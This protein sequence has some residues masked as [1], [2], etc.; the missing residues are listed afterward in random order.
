VKSVGGE[1]EKE[2]ESGGWA[3]ICCFAF[4]EGL[5]FNFGVRIE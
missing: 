4:L 3:S 1:S 2:D 5:G